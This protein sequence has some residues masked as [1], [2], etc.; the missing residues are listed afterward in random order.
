MGIWRFGVVSVYLL[1]LACS[2][3]RPEFF[4]PAPSSSDSDAMAAPSLDATGG[5]SSLDTDDGESDDGN[6]SDDIDR[7]ASGH[8]D[9]IGE[10]LDAPAPI[11]SD[12][13]SGGSRAT[14]DDASTPGQGREDDGVQSTSDTVGSGPVL[15]GSTGDGGVETSEGSS[16][17]LGIGEPCADDDECSAGTCQDSVQG[18][19]VCCSANCGDCKQCAT[20]GNSCADLVETRPGCECEPEDTSNC[21]DGI[22]CTD[23]VCVN[24]QCE[25]PVS[26]GSCLIAGRCVTQGTSEPN[27]PCRFCDSQQ[28]PT[29][30]SAATSQVSCD[31]GLWCNG[32]DSCNGNGAC[33]HEYPNGNRCALSGPCA[34]AT[35][36]EQRDSC[37]ETEGTECGSATELR[38]QDT[39]CGGDVQVRTNVGYC[40][41]QSASCA[42]DVLGT[43]TTQTS[44]NGSQTCDPQTLTCVDTLGCGSTWCDTQESLCWMTSLPIEEMTLAEATS[45]CADLVLAGRSDWRLPSSNELASSARGCDGTDGTLKNDDFRSTCRTTSDDLGYSNCTACLTNGGPAGGCYWATE[46]GL[47]PDGDINIWSSTAMPSL[48][49]V[50]HLFQFR[51]SR[52]G[53]SSETTEQRVRCVTTQ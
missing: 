10:E 24:G 48:P 31:D 19:R 5:V 40:N 1:L 34:L 22:P 52:F 29:G 11:G 4:R 41:G 13:S 49:G 18:G 12:T 25:N 45:Y 15:S 9:P 43:W 20:T 14:A 23:D 8:D 36:N 21:N 28:L 46:L 16:G 30:W 27:N 53:A 44:C 42:D 7:T 32:K 26:A 3:E 38:C 39:A 51:Y 33:V 35:C 6:G 47:C 17:Q 50:Y 2:S 37:F